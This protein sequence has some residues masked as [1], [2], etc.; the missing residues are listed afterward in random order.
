MKEKAWLSFVGVDVQI[1]QALS[2]ER[3]SPAFHTMDDVAL[4]KQ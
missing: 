4:I 2:V 3:R 1:V